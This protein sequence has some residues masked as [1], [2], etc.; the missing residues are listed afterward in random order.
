MI[1]TLKQT[2]KKIDGVWCLVSK[3]YPDWYGIPD[4]GFIWHGE[5]SDALL[6]YHGKVYNSF[7]IEEV[8]WNRWIYDDDG[9]LIPAREKDDTGFSLFMRENAQDVY[10]LFQFTQE[11]TI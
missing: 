1:S 5:Y 7:D 6:E 9:N 4:V 3:E 8:M 10:E 2:S 11:V